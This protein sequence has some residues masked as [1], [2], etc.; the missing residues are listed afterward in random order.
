MEHVRKAVPGDL[1]RIAEIVVFNYRMN[2]YPIFRDERFY[3]AEL[4]VPRVMEE[5]RSMLER[6]LVYD[7]GVVKG[8]IRIAEGEV[9]KLFVE[10]GLQNS[11]VGAALLRHAIMRHGANKLWALE[12]NMGAI[13]FYERNGFRRTEERLLEEGTTE[14]LVRMILD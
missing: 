5:Y 8:F 6:V 12:K 13:R 10:P 3:F 14:Y 1:P 2:F 4:T 7:D 9:E 11:G